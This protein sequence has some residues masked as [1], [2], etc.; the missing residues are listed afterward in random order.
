M[1]I[2][3]IIVTL[4]SGL[5]GGNVAGAAAKDKSLGAIGNSI[6]G[7]VGGTLGTYIAQATDLLSQLQSGNMDL[8][9]LLGNIGVSGVGGAILTLI[10]GYLK[11]FLQK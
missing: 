10:V 9:A 3:N 11:K 7:L 6:A 4:L 5:V 1:D 8:T 2:V